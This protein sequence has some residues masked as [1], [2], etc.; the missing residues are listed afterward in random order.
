MKNND[1][2]PE[3]LITEARAF[4]EAAWN[5]TDSKKYDTLIAWA[6]EIIE[7][8][9]KNKYPPALWLKCS[10]P[11]DVNMT[12][13]E[14]EA[15]QKAEI[16]KAAKAGSIEAKF[17]LACDLDEAPAEKQSAKLFKEAA[18]AGHAYAMW[19]H[20]LNLLS[21][22]GIEKNE[23]EGLSFIQH[24]AELKFEGAIKFVADAYASGTYG[25]QKNQEESALWWKRLS[26]P[27]L[28]H[29]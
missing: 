13:E 5:A 9:A 24:S 7:P 22:R 20:G 16:E 3:L 10:L 27:Y 21:G 12:S 19:C 17:A 1:I 8:L 14:F 6:R 25:Y 2:S 15:I 11:G 26:D 29:Y 28:I 18:E 4:L 23:A